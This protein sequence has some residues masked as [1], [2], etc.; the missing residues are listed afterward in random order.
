MCVPEYF[1]SESPDGAVHPSYVTIQHNAHFTLHT[2]PRAHWLFS[3]LVSDGT[4][5]EFT[6]IP[7]TN[8]TLH[9]TQEIFNQLSW[10]SF[11]TCLSYQLWIGTGKHIT[12]YGVPR[13]T[14]E[15][16]Y[17]ALHM[18]SFFCWITYFTG[19][20]SLPGSINTDYCSFTN[21]RVLGHDFR[22]GVKRF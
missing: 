13:R 14:M 4:P 7:R 1:G 8:L 2:S 11:C 12:L 9:F 21:V 16:T 15:I 10:T 6:M 3:Y 5:Q 22:G 17:V 18:S 19:S 20:D